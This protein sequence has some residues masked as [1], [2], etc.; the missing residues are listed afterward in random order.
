MTRS[1]DKLQEEVAGSAVRDT[2]PVL[3]FA[4]RTTPEA[5]GMQVNES[6]AIPAPEVAAKVIVR[7]RVAQVAFGVA[8]V[9]N[10]TE[11]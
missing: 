8:L 6:C 9:A 7:G 1:G 3:A 5:L 11:A 10:P 2:L 4:S